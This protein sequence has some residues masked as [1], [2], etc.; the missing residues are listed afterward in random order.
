MLE[1]TQNRDLPEVREQLLQTINHHTGRLETLVEDLLDATRLEAGQLTLSLQSTDLR[2]LVERI[3]GSFAPLL[4]QKK[5]DIEL[6]LP[7]TLDPVLLDRHRMEQILANLISNAHRYAAKG[8]H[9]GIALTTNSDYLQLT[10]SDDGPG[11]PLDHQER[12]FDKFYVV[13]GGRHP[14]GVGLGLYITREL[15]ELHG[16]RIWVESEPGKGSVFHVT[17]PKERNDPL[18][19]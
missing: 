3:V 16:G 17:L 18:E 6:V 8:G 12:V 4:E 10:V 13:A 7:A 1:S 2:L 14:T 5:Q 11:I 19:V 9:I 15:V